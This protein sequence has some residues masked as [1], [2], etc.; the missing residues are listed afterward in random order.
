[1]VHGWVG[2]WMLDGWLRMYM[3]GY[4]WIVGVGSWI[5]VAYEN[6]VDGWVDARIVGELIAYAWVNGPKDRSMTRRTDD[7]HSKSSI[8][9]KI[10]TQT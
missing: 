8:D 5:D 2:R 9:N 6:G 3:G 7:G 10:Q 4:V 1:M